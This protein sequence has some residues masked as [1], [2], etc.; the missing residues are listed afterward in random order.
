M[1]RSATRDP[2]RGPTQ[3]GPT[4]GTHTGDP[5]RRPTQRGGPHRGPTT[6]GPTEDPPPEGRATQGTHTEHTQTRVKTHAIGLTLHKT[7]KY[8]YMKASSSREWSPAALKREV[9][10][11]GIIT[12][13]RGCFGRCCS[14]KKTPPYHSHLSCV[15]LRNRRPTLL[16]APVYHTPSEACTQRRCGHAS[17]FLFKRVRVNLVV[18]RCLG[19]GP[20]SSIPPLGR[21]FWWP[22]IVVASQHPPTRPS[23]FCFVGVP[24]LARGF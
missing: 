17:R 22:P 16:R 3:R 20:P 12:S 2:H 19:I 21:C 14:N 13:S 15:T 9:D 23:F 18:S 10:A 6:G 24:V 1:E 4:Q 5:H 7:C 8:E 11:L